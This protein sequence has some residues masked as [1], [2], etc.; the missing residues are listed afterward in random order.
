MQMQLNPNLP[1]V[2]MLLILLIIC[3]L[4]II[5]IIVLIHL[6]KILKEVHNRDQK[7]PTLQIAFIIDNI[8]I[9]GGI[10][11]LKLANDQ[12]A[13]FVV[14][15]PKDKKGEDTTYQAGTLKVT[16]SNEE[17]FTVAR[18]D[19]DPENE[20]AWKAVAGRSGAAVLTIEAD[21]DLGDGVKNIKAEIAVE[22]TAGEAVGFS[23][24]V[25]NV[26]AQPEGNP[27]AQNGSGS[28]ENTNTNQ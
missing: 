18:D 24:P 20:A 5:G 27:P 14:P 6:K 11:M 10:T 28:G 3:F 12:L 21:A 23:E 25:F 13:R 19:K 8:K 4:G 22:V 9:T 16:S 17:V 1:L 26:E 7:T 15:A 2:N